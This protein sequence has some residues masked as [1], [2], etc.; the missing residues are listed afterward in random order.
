MD[1]ERLLLQS[2]LKEGDVE[3]VVVVVSHSV[4]LQARSTVLQRED[5]SVRKNIQAD[6]KKQ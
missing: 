1:V 3:E 2:K 5:V 6:Y 4:Q